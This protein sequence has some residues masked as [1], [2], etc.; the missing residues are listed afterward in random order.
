MN[1]FAGVGAD[2]S[3]AKAR[4]FPVPSGTTEVVP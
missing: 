2:P 3:G 1:G 4:G